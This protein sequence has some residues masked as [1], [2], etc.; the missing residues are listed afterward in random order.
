M[1]KH[2]K[3]VWTSTTPPKHGAKRL[4]SVRILRKD[5][6][7]QRKLMTPKHFKSMQAVFV[8]YKHKNI[9]AFVP[10]FKISKKQPTLKPTRLTGQ[11]TKKITLHIKINYD[12]STAGRYLSNSREFFLEGFISTECLARDV[13]KKALELEAKLKH[14]IQSKFFPMDTRGKLLNNPYY[15]FDKAEFESGLEIEDTPGDPSR[16]IT[17]G[18]NYGYH[19][20][21][22]IKETEL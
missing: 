3:G 11:D 21:Q 10:G 1:A 13:D 9:T 12:K 20:N 8:H 2:V 17:A 7:V 6:V 22:L 19:K 18:A 15:D 16:E 4:I 14:K 5:G